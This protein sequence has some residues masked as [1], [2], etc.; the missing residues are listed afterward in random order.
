MLR[1][2]SDAN[3]TLTHTLREPSDVTH[4]VLHT[5]VHFPHIAQVNHSLNF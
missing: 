2:T 3:P 1:V 5:L 4:S